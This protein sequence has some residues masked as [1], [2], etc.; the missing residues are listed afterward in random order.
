MPSF[1]RIKDAIGYIFVSLIDCHGNPWLH[2]A[3]ILT[4]LVDHMQK[5]LFLAGADPDF[6]RSRG[7]T[8]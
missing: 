8:V 7:F 2:G 3:P 4:S 5:A 1:T 6:V